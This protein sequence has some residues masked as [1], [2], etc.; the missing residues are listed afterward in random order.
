MTRVEKDLAGLGDNRPFILPAEWAVNKFLPSMRFKVFSELALGTRS[1]S[2][3][4]F[5]SLMRTKSVTRGGQRTL[6]CTTLCL[7][8]DLGFR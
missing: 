1:P 4:Q 2:T 8:P 3:S 7:L 5:V 6:G